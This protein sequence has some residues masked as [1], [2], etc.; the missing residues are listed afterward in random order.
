MNRIA[1][2]GADRRCLSVQPLSA[3]AFETRFF[4]AVGRD[5]ERDDQG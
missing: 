5:T 4:I 2:A 1:L 3:K